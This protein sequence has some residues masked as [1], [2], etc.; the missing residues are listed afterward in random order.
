MTCDPTSRDGMWVRGATSPD[1]P[2]M[3][4]DCVR[5]AGV[6]GGRECLK[7]QKVVAVTIESFGVGGIKR[8]ILV[9]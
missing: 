9:K 7:T 8:V 5:F 4:L 1:C 3:V 6:D 2:V